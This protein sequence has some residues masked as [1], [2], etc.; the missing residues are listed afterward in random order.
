MVRAK[1]TKKAASRISKKVEERIV[2]LSLDTVRLPGGN[3]S[4]LELIRHPGASAIVPMLSQG[5]DPEILMLRQFRYAT[6]G[7]VWRFPPVYWT[8]ARIP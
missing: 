7:L 5:D 3:V 2:K 8:R 1:T 4:E 6:G